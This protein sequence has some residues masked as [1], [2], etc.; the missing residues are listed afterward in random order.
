MLRLLPFPAHSFASVLIAF[1]ALAPASSQAQTDY[2]ALC[3]AEDV[4]D[5]LRVEACGF[6]GHNESLTAEE[7]A[8]A[9]SRR[10]LVISGQLEGDGRNFALR[11]LARSD[12]EEAL[13]LA[14]NDTD[15]KRRY[16]TFNNHWTG[17]AEAQLA[18][19][20]ALLAEDG[21]DSEALLQRGLVYM[22]KGDNEKAL[23]DVTKA[24]ELDPKNVEAFTALGQIL[25][26][27][28]RNE[29]SYLAYSKALALA[30]ARVEIRLHRMGPALVSQHFTSVRDDGNAAL[31]GKFAKAHLWDIRG[32]ANYVL[33]DY[34]TAAEDFS[35]QLKLDQA[36]VRSLVWRYLAQYRG[37]MA[38]ESEAVAKAK[39]LGD[40]WPSAVFAFFAG[41]AA[42]A[43]IFA[44]IA[45]SPAELQ[46]T[47]NAQ[48]HFY[49]AEW[50]ILTKASTSSI[51]AHL[52][53]VRDAGVAFGM[54][55]TTLMGQ[56]AVVNDNNILEMSVGA[57]RLREVT[58]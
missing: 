5:R 22:R 6:A 23:A 18:T 3:R 26:N 52:I 2:L 56:P 19:A 40:H 25:T 51:R 21:S 55:Q 11:E 27:M 20:N 47:R 28:M 31:R 42:E 13:R 41:N 48:A 29:E 57:A 1:L 32:A 4:T 53:A 7:R 36:G 24:S 38:D 44:Q 14:P 54:A 46:T 34:K 39:E 33:Q 58:P 49:I 43:D 9:L 10:A 8:D 12:F 45:Q 35:A 37:G 50:G 15:L 30:P 17:K 16:M